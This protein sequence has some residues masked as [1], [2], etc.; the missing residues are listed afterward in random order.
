MKK[1]LATLIFTLV[2]LAVLIPFAS[3]APDGLEKV[4][5]SLGIGEHEPTWSGLMPDYTLPHVENTYVSTLVAGVFGVFLVFG[6]TY[7]LGTVMAKP[8]E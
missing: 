4:A 3:D 5:E 6:V 1:Y 7:L 8:S 2:G